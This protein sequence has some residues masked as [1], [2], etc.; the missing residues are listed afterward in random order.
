MIS[1]KPSSSLFTLDTAGSTSIRTTYRKTHKLLTADL[2]LAQ[3]SALPAVETRKRP[4][5]KVTDGVLERSAAPKKR[6]VS[7]AELDRLRKIAYAGDTVQVGVAELEQSELKDLWTVEEIGQDERDGGKSS[8]FWERARPVRAPNTLRHESVSQLASGKKVP[9]VGK[10]DAGKSYNPAFADWDALIEREGAKAVE[11]ERKRLR[12]AEDERE[13][14]ERVE[15]GAAGV[16]EEADRWPQLGGNESEWESEWEGIQSEVETEALPR[17]LVERK[18][19]AQRNKIKRRKEAE[20]QALYEAKIKQRGRQAQRIKEIANA[21]EED[22][23]A[24]KQRLALATT[25]VDSS[26]DE[27]SDGLRRRKFGNGQ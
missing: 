11:A 12:Q 5:S 13:L 20:R 8:A 16:V 3:R 26:A 4:V 19:Q 25:G 7:R 24:R 1:E 27:A 22:Q 15:R 9:A 23:R 2:I 6:K 21:I 18:T 17:K 14:A 10:P